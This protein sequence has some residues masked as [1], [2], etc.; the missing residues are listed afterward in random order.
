MIKFR[1]IP[2]ATALVASLSL[3]ACTTA[4][5]LPAGGAPASGMAAHDHVAM[6]DMKIKAMQTMRDAMVAAKTPQE[7]N[8]L[9]AEHMKSMQDDMKMMGGMCNMKDM[10]DA[11]DAKDMKGPTGDAGAHTH[12]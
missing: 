8:K 10:K 7:R 3:T 6:M 11:K 1:F 9:M 5:A 12:H 2:L 4:P